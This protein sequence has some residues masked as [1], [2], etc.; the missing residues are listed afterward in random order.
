MKIAAVCCTFNRPKMLGRLI[1]CFERQTYE[2]RELVILDDERVLQSVGIYRYHHPLENAVAYKTRLAELAS[3]IAELVK[4]RGAIEKSKQVHVYVISNRG[5]LGDHVVKI[6]LTRRLEPLDRIREL[7]GASVPF[8]FDVHA[9]FFS[10]DA[11][12]LENELHHHFS[13]RTV[14]RANS[15]K[16]FFFATPAEVREVLA[17]KVG[18]LLEFTEHAEAT[19]YLQ[20]IQYWPKLESLA[21]PRGPAP[22]WDAEDSRF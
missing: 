15:R 6:G 8:R 5:A 19:E 14:N 21:G 18:N 20:A 11:V 9:L 13:D 12:G 1:A 3:R 17:D 10:E 22:A 16:E 7:S 4:S 2:N